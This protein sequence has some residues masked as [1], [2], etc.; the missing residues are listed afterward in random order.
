MTRLWLDDER[1]PL[2]PVIQKMF[3]ALGDELWVK[4]VEAAIDRLNE[5][6]IESVSLDNDLGIAGTENEGFRVARHIEEL[7]ATGS[8]RPPAEMKVHSAN[9]VRRHEMLTAFANARRY[10]ERHWPA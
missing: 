8:A 4:T 10:A 3:G 6:G 9:P 5:G 7:A 1:D 2:D